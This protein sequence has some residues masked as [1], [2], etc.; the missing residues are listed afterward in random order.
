M[1]GASFVLRHDRERPVQGQD[2]RVLAEE[3]TKDGQDRWDRTVRIREVEKNDA[4][5][6]PTG[7][8]EVRR[9]VAIQRDDDPPLSARELDHLSVRQFSE[10]PLERD[11]V[12]TELLREMLGELGREIGIK[13]E[14]GHT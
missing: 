6:W 7:L 12:E 14:R 8:N 2:R 13:Q 5:R 3:S 11:N 4:D 9:E 10:M 1:N